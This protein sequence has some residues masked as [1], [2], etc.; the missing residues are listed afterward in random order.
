MFFAL[1]RLR[2]LLVCLGVLLTSFAG[3]N[4]AGQGRNAGPGHNAKPGHSAGQEAALQGAAAIGALLDGRPRDQ[5]ATLNPA[6]VVPPPPANW[7]ALLI[8]GENYD[9]KRSGLEPLAFCHDDMAALRNEWLI[10][11]G[12]PAEHIVFLNDQ[13]APEL[14]PT[15]ANIER[16]LTAITA[17]LG[18]GDMLLLGA[19][20]HGIQL[21]DRSYLCPVDAT[22]N[23][24]GK[25]VS[26]DAEQLVGLP[27]IFDRVARCR[28]A[29]KLLVFDACRQA[30][31]P[32]R[33]GTNVPSRTEFIASLNRL[34]GDTRGL[35]VL[36]S[37]SEGQSAYELSEMRHGAFMYFFL[38]GLG[39]AADLYTGNHDG[40]VSLRE[41]A[42]YA[43]RETKARIYL[44]Q[45]EWQ[46]PDLLLGESTMNFPLMVVE[47]APPAERAEDDLAFMQRY[48][49]LMVRWSMYGAAKQY[50]LGLDLLTQVVRSQPEN[51]EAYAR[52]AVAYRAKGDYRLA[53]AD[54]QKAG[55][56]LE[57]FVKYEGV[58]LAVEKKKTDP[59]LPGARVSIDQIQDDF[60]WVTAVDNDPSRSLQGWIY[61]EHVT[62]DPGLAELVLPRTPQRRQPDGA[63]LERVRD[64]LSGINYRPSYIPTSISVPSIPSVPRP[65][66]PSIPR[67]SIPSLPSI[68]SWRS[69]VPF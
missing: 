57:L 42:S 68:P 41:A 46:E 16:Q 24:A 59:L 48:G 15:K 32:A 17:R 52:R 14:R 65:S 61:K 36:V 11:A 13:A 53:L 63:V 44:T 64:V 33:P 39:G 7:W 58:P 12:V 26:A 22:L 29:F 40:V 56:T 23:V 50:D 45:K 5:A 67:P 37:C 3:R 1:P 38:K 66:V 27:G 8:A 51:R 28:A 30:I 31:R 54:F 60:L 25:H 35:A 9:P 18:P 20:M 6:P 43:N 49:D 69:F 19:A 4:A 21:D 2:L 34:K 47:K 55:S 10:A 62:W